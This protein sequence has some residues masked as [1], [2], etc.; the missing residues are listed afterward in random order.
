MSHLGLACAVA[1]AGVFL[2]SARGKVGGVR[3]RVFVATAGPLR[4][5]P[6]KWRGMAAAAVATVELAVATAFAVGAAFAVLG[7]DRAVLVLAFLG[8]AALLVAFTIAIVLMLRRG[9]RAP[10][11]CFGAHE[12]P[13]GPAHLVRN[14]ILL[15]LAVTG[16]LAQGSGYAAPGVA[17]AAL[18][19]ALAAALAVRFDDL[20]DLFRAT[21]PGGPARNPG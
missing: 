4:L 18:A 13:L 16:S 19:G 21:S 17:L 5:L 8:A 1:L 15:A 12:A 20:V 14:L 10:C 7:V 11:H 2:V 9:E 3:F 6:R